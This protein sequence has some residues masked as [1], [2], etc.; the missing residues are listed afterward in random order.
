MKTE[1]TIIYPPAI[2]YQFMH[3]RP[4]QMMK[5]FAQAGANVVF[6][7]PADLFPQHEPVIQPYPELPDFRVIHRSVDYK[8]Y[9]R[10]KV[11]FWCAVNQ[12]WFIDSN[13]HDLAVFDSC[14]LAA[15]EFSAWHQLVPVMERK[16]AITFASAQAIYNEHASRGIRTVLLP[17]AADYE[18]FKSAAQ[19][20]SRPSDL[21]QTK[22]EPLIGYY[23]AVTSWMD[24]EMVYAVAERYPVVLIGANRLYDLEV[25][26]PRVTKLEM[27]SYEELPGYLSWF[28]AALIPFRLTPMIEGCDPVKFYEYSSA[29]KPVIASDMPELRKFGNLAYITN[30]TNAPDTVARALADNH[31]VKVRQRQRMAFRNSW[32]NRA[33]YALFVMINQLSVNQ[34]ARKGGVRN[35]N[36]EV[37]E[38]H[39]R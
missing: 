11:V 23:G 39:T 17:N 33:R 35:E 3:Q 28:D 1:I 7:N 31:E 10:G 20:L 32:I 4:H 18:H 38:G 24:L 6:I 12:G 5:A 14:D 13:D 16:T 27:K 9:I 29:G 2:D 30:V 22:D 21:P 34:L 19:R 25:K 8:P 15:D 26:H 36:V 37:K